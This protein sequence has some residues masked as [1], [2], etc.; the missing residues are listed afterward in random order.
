M[1]IPCQDPLPT[2][3]TEPEAA[4][5]HEATPGHNEHISAGQPT[6][7][8]ST[9]QD[10]VGLMGPPEVTGSSVSDVHVMA[11]SFFFFY[12][13]LSTTLYQIICIC[14]VCY[15]CTWLVG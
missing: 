2:D 7:R 1:G 10:L 14:Y 9:S 13:A 5:R 12:I 15:R 4:V 3:E 8:P 6:D 11:F